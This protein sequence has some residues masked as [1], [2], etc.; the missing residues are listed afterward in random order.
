MAEKTI[1]E[2]VREEIL[3]GAYEKLDN[4]EF[5]SKDYYLASKAISELERALSERYKADSER[6]ARTES[7]RYE[8]DARK[9]VASIERDA[10]KDVAVIESETNER[11]AKNEAD[12]RKDVAT[13]ESSARKDVA[14]IESKTSVA[15]AKNEA[16]I[17]ENDRKVEGAIRMVESGVRVFICAMQLAIFVNEL[18]NT[19]RFEETGTEISSGF[20]KL[21]S[22]FKPFDR[23]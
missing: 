15:V 5:G 16:V 1:L 18:T 12:T 17:K 6:D 11:V 4:L 21:W 20:R 8:A 13:I 7:A 10:R 9:D 19:R 3:L 23:Q 14:S 2:N 22:A